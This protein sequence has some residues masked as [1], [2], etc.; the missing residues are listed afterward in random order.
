MLMMV[1]KMEMPTPK[2]MMDQFLARIQVGQSETKE[3]RQYLGLKSLPRF[4]VLDNGFT[5][6]K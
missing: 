2:T 1:P 6:C 4:H 5:K 3:D